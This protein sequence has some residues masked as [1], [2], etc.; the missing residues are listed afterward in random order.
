[1]LDKLEFL[2]VVCGQ[3]LYCLGTFV[4][5]TWFWWDVISENLS[6]IQQFEGY[7]V[8]DTAIILGGF[9]GAFTLLVFQYT[10]ML[11]KSIFIELLT[12]VSVKLG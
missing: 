5:L 6:P 8:Q 11:L 1:M 7:S 3:V 12:K 4:I 10:Y 9:F 2:F